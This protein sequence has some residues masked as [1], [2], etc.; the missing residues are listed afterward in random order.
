MTKELIKAE[1][2]R[3]DEEHLDEL[4]EVV[5]RFARGGQGGKEK[6]TLMDRLTEIEI[7]APEDFA[8]HFDLYLNGEKGA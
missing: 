3:V 8:T 6:S 7:D 1:I 4:Y 5:R 2:D